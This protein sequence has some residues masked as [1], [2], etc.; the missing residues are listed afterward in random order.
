MAANPK[1]RS[2]INFYL[3]D[4]L[5]KKVKVTAIKIDMTV[6]EYIRS[7]IFKDLKERDLKNDKK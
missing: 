5:R 3:P 1:K 2:R 7:L 6:S 4:T